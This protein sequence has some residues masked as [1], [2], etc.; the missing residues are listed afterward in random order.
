MNLDDFARKQE[1]EIFRNSSYP[2]IWKTTECKM[3]E[4]RGDRE[5]HRWSTP[6]TSAPGLMTECYDC[7]ITRFLRV[8][9][10]PDTWIN[11]NTGNEWAEE[12]L[13]ILN[14]T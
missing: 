11:K 12:R 14:E 4:C 10:E 7:H 13:K 3:G 9:S 6:M 1:K 2:F 5:K 8:D